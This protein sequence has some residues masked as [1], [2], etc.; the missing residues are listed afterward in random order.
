VSVCE[1]ADAGDGLAVITLH[2]TPEASARGSAIFAEVGQ[3]TMLYRFDYA[4]GYE[5]RISH[6]GRE[7]R[8]LRMETSRDLKW[9]EGFCREYALGNPAMKLRRVDASHPPGNE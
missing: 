9:A 2:L 6:D 1:V 7:V 4:G 5:H 3:K 8:S